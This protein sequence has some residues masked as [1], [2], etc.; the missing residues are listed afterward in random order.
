MPGIRLPFNCVVCKTRTTPKTRRKIN[1]EL[2]E[3]ILKRFPL[4]IKETDVICNKCRFKHFY[5]SKPVSTSRSEEITSDGDNNDEDFNPPV[6]KKSAIASPP[7]VRL[8]IPTTPKSHSRCFICKRPGPKLIVV[9]SEARFSAFAEHNVIIKSG[10]RCCPVHMDE[11]YKLK[12]DALKS[13]NKT[14]SAYVNRATVLELLTKLREA[15]KRCTKRFD[16]SSLTNDEYVDLTGIS[17]TAFDDLCSCV[18]GHIRNT[19]TRDVRTTIGIFFFK[20][21]S[22]LSNKLLSVIFGIT[23]S[24]IRRAITSVRLTLMAKFVPNNLGLQ[25]IS[26]EDLIEN[27]TRQ[28]ATSL[29]TNDSG[30]S[31]RLILV[32][33]GT[34]IYIQK[35]QNHRFQRRSYSIHKGRPLVKPMVIVTTTGYYLTV[36]GPYLSDGKNSDA[37]ILNHILNS[38]IEDIKSYIR[39]DDIFVVDRGF[40]DSLQ[41]LE[42]WFKLYLCTLGSRM[43]LNF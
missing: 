3:Q 22:G 14:E 9:P 39:Q 10:T 30:D 12:D 7:S 18:E 16:F 21:R 25:H 40:R 27:H 41:L 2:K 13:A 29:F 33:D 4:T 24:S 43:I 36:V 17:Q 35:S 23:K 28:L 32:L 38:N 20:I 1:K 26:R 11:S 37:K 19:P 5:K 6:P 34:Y 31:S 42:V 8:S 15:C